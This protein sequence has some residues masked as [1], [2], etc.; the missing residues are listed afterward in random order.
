MAKNISKIL[1][2]IQVRVEPGDIIVMYTDGI[3]E[4]RNGNTTASLMFGLDRLLDTINQAP[5]KTAQGVFNHITIELSKFMGYNH[6]QFDDITLI[7]M[8]YRGNT[9][10][11]HDVESEISREFIT[12]WDWRL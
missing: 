4:A 11:E 9:P 1:K 8:H 10:I 5:V 7:C 12:E 2:E 6:K 3:T